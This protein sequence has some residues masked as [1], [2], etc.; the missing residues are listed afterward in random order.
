MAAGAA[1]ATS[2]IAERL[3][4]RMHRAEALRNLSRSAHSME[5]GASTRSLKSA[6]LPLE[7]RDQLNT[8]LADGE[9]DNRLVEWLNSNP[10]VTHTSSPPVLCKIGL[11]HPD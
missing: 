6:R 7:I 2:S 1:T 4:H 8:R 9:P 10:V 3:P 11:I 5:A